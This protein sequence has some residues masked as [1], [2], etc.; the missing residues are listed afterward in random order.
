MTESNIYQDIYQL[1]IQLNDAQNPRDLVTQALPLIQEHCAFDEAMVYFLDHNGKFCGQYLLNITTQTS[2]FYRDYYQNLD[3]GKYS[4]YKSYPQDFL[5]SRPVIHYWNEETDN[6]FVR[7]F[8]LPR[9]LSCSIGFALHDLYHNPRCVIALDWMN[10]RK[11]SESEIAFL[12]LFMPLLDSMFRKFFYQGM[13]ENALRW[14]A[15]GLAQLTSRES[16][17]VNLLGQGVSP[18]NISKKLCISRATTYRHIANIY[19]KMQVTNRQE[20]MVLLLNL[21][22]AQE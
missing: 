15:D 2:T 10:H 3:E 18:A 7:D 21:K 14:A 13:K 4:I 22:E 11:P 19:K 9:K 1:I 17:I 8:I 16:E 5:H 12:N 6:E 20:L